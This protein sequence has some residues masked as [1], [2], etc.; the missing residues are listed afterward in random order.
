MNKQPNSRHCF[1]CGIENPVGLHLKFYETGPGEVTADYT[2]PEHFQGYPGVLHGGIVA[3]ILDETAGR[4]HMGNFPP[5]FMFTAK[6]EVRYRKNV[7]VGQ[8]L[9]IVG[10]AGRDKGRAAEAT[11]AIYSQDGTLLAE[12]NALMINLP[13]SPDPNILEKLGWKVYPDE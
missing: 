1:V 13:E 10:R 12:A 4:A 11:S 9:K 7:P 2:A 5:R 3:A 6:L 8:P